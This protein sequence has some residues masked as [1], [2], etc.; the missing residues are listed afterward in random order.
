MRVL[1][2]HFQ[3]LPILYYPAIVAH[4]LHEIIAHKHQ[5]LL[6]DEGKLSVGVLSFLKDCLHSLIE[7]AVGLPSVPLL[8]GLVLANE[9]VLVLLL[10]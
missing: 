1:Q 9:D 5:K 2:I 3:Q 8:D 6:V 10:Q 4:Q 7:V